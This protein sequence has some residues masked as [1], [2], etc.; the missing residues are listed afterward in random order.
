MIAFI[1]VVMV[2]ALFITSQFALAQQNEELVTPV[3][4]P[5][6][7]HV[8]GDM[9]SVTPDSESLN[10]RPQLL[11]M[12]RGTF[13]IAYGRGLDHPI[14]IIF[15]ENKQGDKLSGRFIIHTGMCPGTERTFTDGTFSNGQVKFSSKVCAPIEISAEIRGKLLH[16]TM[17]GRTD[18]KL[19]AEKL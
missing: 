5:V 8:P 16:G 11:G 13:T 9:I 17:S 19:T 4:S 3:N 12:Y 18:F 2:S 1:K 10:D 7:V 6:N 15:D 14:D